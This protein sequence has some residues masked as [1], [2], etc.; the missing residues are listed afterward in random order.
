MLSSPT[1]P[2]REEI[3]AQIR[4]FLSVRQARMLTM[5]ESR[6]YDHLVVEWFAAEQGSRR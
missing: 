2:S 3:N 6:E 4:A 1:L 5:E